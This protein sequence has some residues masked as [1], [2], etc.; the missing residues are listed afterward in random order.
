M[1]LKDEIVTLTNKQIN[2]IFVDALD[3]VKPTI[4]GCAEMRALYGELEGLLGEE[5]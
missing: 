5:G 3:Q 2:Q 1:M 4:K